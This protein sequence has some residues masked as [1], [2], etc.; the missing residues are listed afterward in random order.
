MAGKATPKPAAK[1]QAPVETTALAVLSTHPLAVMD[2]HG[3]PF[4]NIPFELRPEGGENNTDARLTLPRLKV[5]Q[6]M[7][8]ELKKE[9]RVE[10]AEEGEYYN[11]STG[12]SVETVEMVP[13]YVFQERY[14]NVPKMS[15]NM[16]CTSRDGRGLYGVCLKGDYDVH[17][18]PTQLI[19]QDNGPEMEVGVCSRCPHGMRGF[20]GSS[21]CQHAKILVMVPYEFIQTWAEFMPRITTVPDE[22]LVSDLI[23]ALCTLGFRSTGL[24]AFNMIS[25]QSARDMSYFKWSWKFSTSPQSNDKGSWNA[26]VVQKTSKLTTDEMTFARSLYK[27]AQRIRP[28]ISDVDIVDEVPNSTTEVQDL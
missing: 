6:P 24:K 16:V 9:T 13:L 26:I 4:V 23:N 14:Y 7:S 20:G 21:D 22:D 27:L 1:T 15:A 11:T 3:R 5:L 18:I 17:R 10:G 28:V 2:D 19:K 25:D 8:A 12:E